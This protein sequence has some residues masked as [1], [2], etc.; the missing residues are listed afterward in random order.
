MAGFD[1]DPILQWI[2]PV[3]ELQVTRKDV[4]QRFQFFYPKSMFIWEGK[5][6]LFYHRSPLTDYTQH[7]ASESKASYLQMSWLGTQAQVSR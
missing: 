6:W 5:L 4:V 3:C 2:G 1:G 7:R